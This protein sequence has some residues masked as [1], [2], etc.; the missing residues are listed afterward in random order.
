MDFAEQ[1]ALLSELLGDPNTSSDDQWPLARRKAALNRGDI[2]FCKDS[3]CVREY[4]TGA[5]AAYELAVPSGWLE[6]F[7]LIINNVVIDNVR[8]IDLH[9]W[10]VYE[11]NGSDD[12]F[13]YIWEE[14]GVRKMKFLS[15]SGVNGQTY[16]L[17]YFRKQT[18]ALSADADESII[19]DE[20]REGPVYHAASWLLNQAGLTDL[21]DRYKA[22]YDRLVIE[23]TVKTEKEYKK[24]NRPFPDM[25]E[26]ETS[27]GYSQGDG[28]YFG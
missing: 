25:G 15:G 28:G 23:A 8:E 11:V 1:Q 21:A 27:G 12:P 13:Y 6:T 4:A 2:H 26:A 17:Y 5:I 22:E 20:Y 9:E 3:H 24:E 19:P 18:T 7:C 14:S 10:E 16:K